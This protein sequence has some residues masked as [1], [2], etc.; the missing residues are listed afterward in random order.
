MQAHFKHL[1]KIAVV[2][3]S[4]PAHGEG[5][6]THETIDGGGIERIDQLL[7]VTFIVAAAQKEVQEATD[8]HVRDGVE[9]VEVDVVAPL[10]LTFPVGFK[11]LLISRQECS[12]GI[13]D[14]VKHQIAP[15]FSHSRAD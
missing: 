11:R 1:I 14:Q 15:V 2:K 4:I 6:A 12:H 3:P 9:V 13:C 8:G 5:V 10:Q 7:H